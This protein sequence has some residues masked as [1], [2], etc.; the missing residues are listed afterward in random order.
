MILLIDHYDSFT[1]NIYQAVAE[2]GKDVEVIRYGVLSVEEIL[3]KR[4]E[5][6]ILSPG[7]GHPDT[8]AESIEL[9]QSAAGNVPILGVCLGHQMIGAAFGGTIISAPSIRHGKV[10]EIEHGE[11]GIFKGLAEPLPVMRYHSLVLEPET[12][13]DCLE[14]HSLA[15]DDG[16]I[17]AIKHKDFPVY[18]V[19]FHPES[20]GTP[21]G[22]QLFEG[23]LTNI[24][25]AVII[26]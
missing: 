11:R 26:K 10:S 7:P 6:I 16:T 19:Q 17:M 24:K 1:Y 13:P 20:I 4:P 5:A 23:F 3:A 22:N 21:A 2:L 15:L 25:S 12:L 8:L 14:I 18:G 9:V